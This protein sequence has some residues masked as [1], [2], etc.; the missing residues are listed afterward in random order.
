MRLVALREV[1]LP[2]LSHGG[3]V[4]VGFPCPQTALRGAGALGMWAGTP[5]APATAHLS[6]NE[7]NSGEL[8]KT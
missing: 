1:S 7:K 8:R 3:Q 6:S 2:G 4:T 5:A